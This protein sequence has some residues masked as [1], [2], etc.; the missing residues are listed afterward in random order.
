MT[1]KCETQS[2]LTWLGG[3]LE[4]A[5]DVAVEINDSGP[6]SVP[7]LSPAYFDIRFRSEAA[8][9]ADAPHGTFDTCHGVWV[10]TLKSEPEIYIADR[11]N[12]RIEVFDLELTYK[13]TVRHVR[14]PCC[15]Y[16]FKDKLY[17][18]DLGSRVTILDAQDQLVAHLG[19]LF[20]HRFTGGTNPIDIHEYLALAHPGIDLGYDL[21]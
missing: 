20:K 3:L 15:F 18:P 16:Q 6:G 19:D 21:V 14:N 4:T 17:I 12:S 9:G 10:N 1:S 13:R 2:F 5:R 8:T 11:H 7:E